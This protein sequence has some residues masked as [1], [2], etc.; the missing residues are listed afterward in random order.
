MFGSMLVSMWLWTRAGGEI[1]IN[2][3]GK[4]A[5]ILGMILMSWTTILGARIKALEDYF[6]SQNKAYINHHLLGGTSFLLLLGHPILLSINYLKFSTYAA[7]SFLIPGEY[8][9]KNYGIFALWLMIVLLALTLFVKIDYKKWHFSHKFMS[10][11][12]LLAGL[13]WL[14]ISSD[15]ANDVWL[16]GYM[17]M[18]YSLGAAAIVYRT[19]LPQTLI[20]KFAYRV[21]ATR[22]KNKYLFLKLKPEDR[23]MIYR[24]GQFVFLEVF[25]ESHPLSLASKDREVE[26]IV[27]LGGDWTERLKELK[28]GSL[29][30]IEGP[31]GKFGQTTG[32]KEEVWVAGGVG[33]VP[34][35][36][37]AKTS[38]GKKI[39]LFYSV[40]SKDE[41]IN[42]KEWLSKSSANFQVVL[43]ES[44]KQGRLTAE[45]LISKN[46]E[47]EYLLCGPTGMTVNIKKELIKLNINPNKII[48][49]EFFLR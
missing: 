24:P 34:F 32:V 39:K 7:W 35:I 38:S 30:K 3:A 12:F 23:E 47:T 46:K 31:F 41:L 44:D 42:E 27:K 22:I 49:E 15:V 28:I 5:G 43:I 14:T 17:I 11:V 4:L 1:T 40:K 26:L 25:G 45:Q 37:L 13:H 29:V 10:A 2:G 36:G 16:R 33:I 20:K 18:I 6:Y 8:L 19:I 21:S 9:A 48:S